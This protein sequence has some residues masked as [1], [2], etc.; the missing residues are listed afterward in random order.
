MG[1]RGR[2]TSRRRES[3]LCFRIEC[4]GSRMRLES[5]T[6]SLP[7]YTYSAGRKC[8]QV[9]L[10]TRQEAVAVSM[11]LSS[12]AHH[13]LTRKRHMICAAPWTLV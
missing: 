9:S 2:R 7:L 8:G 1:G 13:G 5:R 3:K 12:L 10:R 11:R 6:S 4:T